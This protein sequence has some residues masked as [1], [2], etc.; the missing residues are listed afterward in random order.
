M[1]TIFTPGSIV[2]C[3]DRQWVILPSDIEKVIRLRPLSGNEEEI[4]GMEYLPI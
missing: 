1:T 3:R 4:C 2:A